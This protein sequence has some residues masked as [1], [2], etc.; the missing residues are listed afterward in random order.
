M[1]EYMQWF[2]ENLVLGYF[3]QDKVINSIFVIAIVYLL[4]FIILKIAFNKVQH[5][6]TR[7][8]WGKISGYIAFVITVLIV[9]RIWFE[10]FKSI[11][12]FIGII[13][14][15]LTIALKDLV[16]GVAGWAFILL[17][18]PFEVGDRIQIGENIGD[19]IDIRVFQ[20]TLMEVGN[21]VDAHQSTGRV[22]HIPNGTVFTTPQANFSKGFRYIW[23]EIPVLLTFES[24]WKKAKEILMELVKKH[25]D[26]TA[27][28]AEHQLREAARKY[29]IS[30]SKLT[31]T[32]YTSVRD[33]GVLLTLRYLCNPKQRR[34]S[35]QLIWEDILEEFAKHADMD[36]AYPTQRFYNNTI[37]A[38]QTGLASEGFPSE[39]Q[40]GD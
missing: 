12:T 19:V 36:F 38:K 2:E 24:D 25:G 6:R 40:I 1:Q 13:S 35:E 31:P 18:R 7:Y 20:F 28:L 33:S 17:R 34:N 5:L 21:W 16:V 4:R 26:D 30:Y 15:A 23:N 29:M 37:E 32:V 14:A 3:T 11:T 9:G 39:T 22:I 10:G 8:R 27:K